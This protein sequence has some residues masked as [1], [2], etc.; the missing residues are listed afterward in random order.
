MELKLEG[1]LFTCDGRA[2]FIE[3][4]EITCDEMLA[5]FMGQNERVFITPN[6]KLTQT[7]MEI[8]ASSPCE[9]TAGPII[10]VIGEKMNG[11]VQ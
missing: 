3:D 9:F 6:A 5:G 8:L 1:V 4:K 10:L 2:I 7:Q 11:K